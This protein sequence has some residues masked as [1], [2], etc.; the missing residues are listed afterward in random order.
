MNKV[1]VSLVIICC[2]GVLLLLAD[3]APAGAWF[4]DTE[5]IEGITITTGSW[6][7]ADDLVITA[8][9]P[10]LKP[11]AG[12]HAKT[13][14]SG[15]TISNTGPVALAITGIR[16]SWSP[17]DGEMISEAAFTRGKGGKAPRAGPHGSEP[18]PAGGEGFMVF[19]SGEAASDQL[20][21]GQAL[22]T[23]ATRNDP[24]RG[25]LLSFDS[26]MEGKSV[27]CTV[28]LDDGGEKEVRLE[29]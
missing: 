12:N 10:L 28:V 5:V 24:A 7:N 19:W 27:V 21:E 1:Y 15:I 20:L 23:P 16:V 2:A 11:P 14:L 8:E 29:V 9:Q 13:V 22:L 18:E 6:S 4:T 25:I 3:V 26:N 17:D